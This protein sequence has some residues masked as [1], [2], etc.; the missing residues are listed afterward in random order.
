MTAGRGPHTGWLA[1]GI[2]LFSALALAAGIV[3]GTHVPRRGP[4]DSLGADFARLQSSLH[5]TAG[6]A[7]SA[8]GSGRKPLVLGDLRSGAAWST[9]KVPL[10]IAAL[11]AE[12]PPVVT[13]AMTVAITESDNAAAESL[14]AG[15][16]DPETAARAVDAVLRQAGDPTSV[17]SRRTRPE[18]SAFG[19]T[20][21][22]LADQVRFISVAWCDP[23]NA[24]VF[25][26]MG[27]VDAAQRWG[28]GVI[29]G[30]RFKG[31]WG[32]SPAGG[33]LVRQLGVLVTPTGAT[34]ISLAAQPDSGR[35]EDGIAD[36]SKIADWLVSHR[37]ALPAGSCGSP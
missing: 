19:Q 12:K 14:W 36:L 25:A 27:H 2:A 10:V 6:I 30:A 8:V 16:G 13:P 28:I 20:D 31:G 23:V 1:A 35:F 7:I 33:Y 26:L 4:E 34:A 3:I 15:L 32:P 24:P 37:A 5:A 11:R 17:Q 21:W 29:D 22:A 9:I 18:F